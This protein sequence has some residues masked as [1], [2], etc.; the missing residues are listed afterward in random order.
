MAQ[1]A[2]LLPQP[3]HSFAPANDDFRPPGRDQDPWPWLI[4]RLKSIN[5]PF[6]VFAAQERLK[7]TDVY[8]FCAIVIA[9][10]EYLDDLTARGL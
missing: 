7:G 2:A 9:R 10:F 6:A 1:A 5:V 3:A 4:E 8:E